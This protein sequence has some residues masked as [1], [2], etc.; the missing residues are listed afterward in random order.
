[1][2]IKRAWVFFWLLGLIWGLSFLLI[3]VTVRQLTPFEVVLIRTGIAAL[4][5]NL[6]VFATGKRYPADWPT[7][8]AL[9]II[10]L[11]N[12]VAPFLLITWGEKSID[13][14]LAS[15]LQ[16][17]AALFTLVVAHFAF[18]DERIT[19]R[20]IGGLTLGFIGVV[21][22]ASRSWKDGQIITG[23][24]LG[25][26][27]I[28]GASFCYAT[29][30]TYSRKVIRKDIAPIVVAAGAMTTA[31]ITML[32]V[33]LIAPLVGGDT[34][35]LLTAAHTIS[36]D[37]LGAVITLGVVNTFI[38]YTMYYSV[39][40]T[41]GAAR[42][43]LVTYIVPLVGLV[44]GALILKEQVDARL[45]LGA[46]FIIGGIGIV[47]LRLGQYFKPHLQTPK[48]EPLQDAAR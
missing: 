4:G 47:N 16:A 33:T 22:L 11:G 1:M 32:V 38:A 48:A 7:L 2:N 8:R 43:S 40:Q 18:A 10:G 35:T 9:I 27:A 25:Q 12:T 26:L 42:A 37:V 30:T 45:L 5:L 39:V 19:P 23:S 20:K 24:L 29:F 21:I 41:L 17:T 3:R 34:P 6:I 14:G 28:V 31:T 13:S 46:V 36:S 15:V 44:L